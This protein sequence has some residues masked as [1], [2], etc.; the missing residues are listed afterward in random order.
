MI[1][2]SRE[3]GVTFVSSHFDIK[4][5]H[6]KPTIFR[7]ESSHATSLKPAQSSLRT[8]QSRSRCFRPAV[9][10]RPACG[11][12]PYVSSCARAICATAVIRAWCLPCRR[13]PRRARGR[14]GTACTSVVCTAHNASLAHTT[15]H[16][17][18][19]RADC[20][21]RRHRQTQTFVRRP[22]VSLNTYVH[23][24]H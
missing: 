10:S 12:F 4:Q 22:C 19:G 20:R 7:T 6:P 11:M 18:Y 23:H 3:D 1:Q 2:K 15:R 14:P 16:D 9:P 21:H 8:V 17:T 24:P 5:T 13:L